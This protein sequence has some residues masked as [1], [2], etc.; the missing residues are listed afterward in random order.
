MKK[1][2]LFCTLILA[3]AFASGA[4]NKNTE[5][6]VEEP[7]VEIENNMELSELTADQIDI[8]KL[9][10]TSFIDEVKAGTMTYGVMEEKQEKVFEG[11]INMG[12]LPDNAV[13]LFREWKTSVDYDE[14]L[15]DWVFDSENKPEE[16][17]EQ[18]VESKPIVQNQNKPKPTEKQEQT[19]HKEVTQKPVKP[20]NNTPSDGEVV[21]TP[22]E[23]ITPSGG[24]STI[25]EAEDVIGD[26]S[27]SF[28]RA[29]QSEAQR[30]ASE[31]GISYEQ[32]LAQVK[33]DWGV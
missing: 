5:P 16:E 11:Y 12:E 33:A 18:K 27:D 3:M 2:I 1:K 10:S 15:M 23:V 20:S 30:I 9:T 21:G 19:Q 8:F 13:E 32:A 29:L 28:S 31:Q 25:T 17:V 22:G 24:G 26:I 4:C 14:K 7:A 6:A